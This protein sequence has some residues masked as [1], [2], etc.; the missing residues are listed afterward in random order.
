MMV[1]KYVY[2]GEIGANWKE[3]AKKYLDAADKYGISEL[4][5]Q[6][7]AWYV[8]YVSFTADNVIEDLLSLVFRLQ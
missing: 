7:E 1:L 4:K 8:T 2:G 6:A 5:V 3:D